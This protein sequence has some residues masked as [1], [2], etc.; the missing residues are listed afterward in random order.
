M[1]KN[2]AKNLSFIFI[3]LMLCNV[4]TPKIYAQSSSMSNHNAFAPQHRPKLVVGIVVDQMRYDYITRYWKKFGDD[5]FKKLVNEGFLLNNTHY[6]Y[7]PTYT[8]PGHS[9]IYTGTTPSVHGIVGNNWFNRKLERVIYVTD[10]STVHA[11][12]G[13]VDAGKMSPAHQLSTTVTD[14]LKL[15]DAQSKVIGVSIKDRSSILPAGH[16]A[17][18]DYWYDGK[19]GDFMSSSWYMDQLPEW[20]NAFN[21]KELAEKYSKRSWTP[22]LP[23]REYTESGPDN[24]P[25]ERPFKQGENPTFPYNLGRYR[26]DSFNIIK[27]TPYGN[28]LVEKMAKAAL[29]GEQLGNDNHTDF[30]AVSFSSTDYVGHQFGPNAVETEDTYLR[31]DQD[32]SDFLNYIDQKV[33]KNNVLVFLTADHGAVQVPQ[34]LKDDGITAGYFD[35]QTAVDSLKKYLSKTY[36]SDKLVRSYIN[37]QVYLNRPLIKESG[38]NLRE[39]QR[40]SADFLM[41]FDGIRNTN[42]ADNLRNKAYIEG[43]QSPYQNGF[44]YNRSGDVYLE[45]EPG[46]LDS[47]SHQ[48]TSHGSP[49]QYDTHVPLIFYGWNIKHGVSSRK[50]VIPDIAVTLSNLLHIQFPDG[51]TG[52]VIEFD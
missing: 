1:I 17:D 43:A 23:V 52:S 20:V 38:L 50:T 44:Y 42:T 46:W 49:Y 18:A 45:L 13:S 48:G 2:K 28:T 34:K 35:H 10:D 27:S 12:G 33:G 32:L 16:L 19:T 36:N 37:Q 30:L 11:M 29:D 40:K 8:G 5:G 6:N 51:A 22:L 24:R 31:L 15:A 4:L 21:N 26:G 47:Q 41:Q 14:Q 39:I 7:F 3:C 25:Y 9:S